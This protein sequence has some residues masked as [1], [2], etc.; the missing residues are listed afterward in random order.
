M[1]N[2]PKRSRTLKSHNSLKSGRAFLLLTLIVLLFCDASAQRDNAS[3]HQ[4]KQTCVKT[5]QNTSNQF[6]LNAVGKVV[7][8]ENKSDKIR[9]VV[10]ITAYGKTEEQA[11]ERL[12]MISVGSKQQKGIPVLEVKVNNGL[13]LKKKYDIVTEV[14][15]PPTVTIQ[16]NDNP[17]FMELL[18]RLIQKIMPY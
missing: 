14:Y 17:N 12:N 15:L 9:C 16:H 1:K 8:K 13:Y 3:C 18:N 7:L 11:A 6:L 4:A 5:F 10:K 2:N